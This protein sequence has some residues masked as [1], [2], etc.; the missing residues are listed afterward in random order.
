MINKLAI[1]WDPLNDLYVVLCP[2]CGSEYTRHDNCSVDVWQRPEDS[3]RDGIS[4]G[5]DGKTTRVDGTSNPSAR[6]SG[7]RLT[8]ACEGC[9]ETFV[10][11]IAQHKGLSLVYVT[12]NAKS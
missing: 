1:Q 4:I 7:L 6:R 9:P 2:H 5:S 11:E 12:P 8:F 10:M 3:K